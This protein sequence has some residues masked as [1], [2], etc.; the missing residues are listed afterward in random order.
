[1][2]PKLTYFLSHPI[3]YISP[4]LQELAKE[5]D[6]EVYYYS[7]IGITG[8]IDKGFGKAIQWDTP[9]LEVYNS[10]FL[11]NYSKSDSMN[12]SFGDALN[13]GFWNVMRKSKNIN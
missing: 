12:C 1:M 11:K 5:V 4:L 2:K 7:N 8:G 3:Q 10:K 13:F 6:L 9:L